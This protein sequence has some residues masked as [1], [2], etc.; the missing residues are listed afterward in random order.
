MSS[1][2][3]N[4]AGL[5]EVDLAGCPTVQPVETVRHDLLDA[6]PVHVRHEVGR[7]IETLQHSPLLALNVPQADVDQPARST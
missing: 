4:L 2:I 5:P 1:F 3:S 7:D 6:E